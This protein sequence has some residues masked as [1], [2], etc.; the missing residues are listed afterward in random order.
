M[1][2]D[3]II[4][5]SDELKKAMESYECDKK[6]CLDLI[7]AFTSLACEYAKNISVGED[8][9][10]VIYT[11]LACMQAFSE[12]VAGNDALIRSY[13]ELLNAM[14]SVLPMDDIGKN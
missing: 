13:F 3:S 7:A 9:E 2:K 6:E 11:G 4:R 14:I 12:M 5:T 10:N 8:Y 1:D